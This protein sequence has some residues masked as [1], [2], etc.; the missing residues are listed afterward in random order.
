MGRPV[1]SYGY[2]IPTSL[3]VTPRLLPPRETR[4]EWAPSWRSAGL[5]V[6]EDHTKHAAKS[7]PTNREEGDTPC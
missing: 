7:G 2:P 6:A 5:R 1:T 4:P 3:P